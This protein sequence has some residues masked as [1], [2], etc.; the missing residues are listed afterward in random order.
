MRWVLTMAELYFF[1]LYSLTIQCQCHLVVLYRGTLGQIS[2]LR[3]LLK[4]NSCNNRPNYGEKVKRLKLDPTI[5]TPVFF[6]K[7]ISQSIHVAEKS[8]ENIFWTKGF[9]SC[10][11]MLDWRKVKRDLYYQ[12]THNCIY[13][14][15]SHYIKERQRKARN[16]EQRAITHLKPGQ[17]RRKLNL[18]CVILTPIHLHMYLIPSQYL[19][20]RSKEKGP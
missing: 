12:K 9:N 17:T 4:H 8:Q 20:D 5:L 11:S 18:V 3:V 2:I 16:F 6:S 13:L 19:K 15:S 1:S 10:K 14:I 7:S